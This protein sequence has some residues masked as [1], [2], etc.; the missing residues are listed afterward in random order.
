MKKSFT[1]AIVALVV[2]NVSYASQYQ[3]VLTQVQA[4]PSATAGYIRV[5]INAGNTTATGCAGAWAGWYSFELPDSSATA[6]MWNAIL[7]S[8]ITTGKSVLIYGQANGTGNPPGGPN[9]G[10]DISGLEKVSSISALP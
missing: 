1:S 8:A 4:A 7:L 2:A 10:C 9:D 6:S 3:G 5:S